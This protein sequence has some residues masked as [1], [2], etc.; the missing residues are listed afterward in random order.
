MHY[1]LWTIQLSH[2]ILKKIL[3]NKEIYDNNSR[4]YPSFGQKERCIPRRDK[5]KLSRRLASQAEAL[6]K[7]RQRGGSS[8]FS[9]GR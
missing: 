9:N 5:P 1:A 7:S 8:A 6:T 3:N 4:S 2:R